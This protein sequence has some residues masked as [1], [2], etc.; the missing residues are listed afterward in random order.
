MVAATTG[1]KVTPIELFF[2][3][4]FVFGLTQITTLMAHDVSVHGIV[5]GLLV[6][7]LLWWSWVGYAWLCNN[8][9]ADEGAIR[10]ALFAVMAAM[11][12]LALAIPQAFTDLTGGHNGPVVVALC[13]FA[14]RG[15]HLVL[16]WII[17]RTDPGLRSQLIR[18]APSVLGGT[19]LL[20]V[21]SRFTGGMQTAL[22]ALALLSDYG[23]TLLAGGS[24]WRL[25]A[26]GHFAER[27]GLIIIVALGESIVAIGVGMAGLPISWPVIAASVLGLTVCA[28]LW[29]AYF[30]TSALLGERALVAE[31]EPDR[32][33]LARDAY[34]FLH[35]PMVAGIVLL[36]LGLKKVLQ[37]VADA[38]HDEPLA[39][40]A[41]YGGVALY[42]LA[43]VAFKM[44]M[45][46]TV[47]VHR[48]VVAI[49]LL[50]LAPLATRLTPL[51]ALAMLSG[52]LAMLVSFETIRFAAVRDSVR[53]S[54]AT[55]A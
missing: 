15:L 17:S 43:H 41:L 25:R 6:L 20:L 7:G 55:P 50:A 32:A 26:P 34:S 35:L 29:W 12:L 54:P 46:R 27:H 37:H 10:A 33:R 23:G 45:L 19:A 9:V 2:D 36:A 52:V 21:A 13:Y 22:W 11:F 51:A 14:F 53:H 3:L 18:W 38:G 28:A 39:L 4:V 8:M 31:P 44:R 49:A 42:L 30:D 24:G 40:A 48:V 16:F 47:T 1:A 5:R